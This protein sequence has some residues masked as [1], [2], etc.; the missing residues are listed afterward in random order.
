ME[1]KL[2]D[3]E[4]FKKHLGRSDPI[5]NRVIRWFS[6][7]DWVFSRIDIEC[8]EYVSPDCFHV[9]PVLDHTMFHRVTQLQN[10]FEFFLQVAQKVRFNSV[11]DVLCLPLASQ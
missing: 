9:V 2:G 8:F 6:Q 10:A 1:E 5:A 11:V 4:V 3:L 7:Q